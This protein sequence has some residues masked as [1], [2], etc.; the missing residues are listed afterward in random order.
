MT[1]TTLRPPTRPSPPVRAAHQAERLWRASPLTWFGLVLGVLLS[2]FPFYW[3]IVIASRTN[4]A[5]NSWPPPFLPGGKLGENI[6]RVLDNGDANIVKGLL[7]SF[8]VSGTITIATVFFGSLAGFAFAWELA[9]TRGFGRRQP[10]LPLVVLG[11]CLAVVVLLSGQAGAAAGPFG[12]WLA[13]VPLPV[14]RDLDPDEALLLAGVVLVQLSTGNVLVRLVLRAT[15]TVN[16]ARVSGRSVPSYRLKGGRL[17]GPMERVFIV[18][19]GLAG[20]LTAASVVVAAKGLLRWPE[21]QAAR[22]E[23]RGG[24]GIHAVTEYFLVGSFVSWMLALGS[25]VLLA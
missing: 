4:D 11:A 15:G 6:Q 10:W 25:L 5:A 16:P 14:L 19:L 3:M 13:Q 18:G 17:L 7:N 24:P 8:L 1:T 21:L 2:L 22:A 9:V 20:E 23:G 12:E